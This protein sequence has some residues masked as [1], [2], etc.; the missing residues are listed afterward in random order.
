MSEQKKYDNSGILFTN[1]KKEKDTHPDR[2][3]TA[4]INGVDYYISGW[5]KTGN[6]GKFLTLSFK[7]K[8]EKQETKPAPAKTQIDKN[9]PFENFD[10][11]IPF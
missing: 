5:I 10:D 6:K 1:D 7:R 4:C 11:D 2:T 9:K 3:G 8:D